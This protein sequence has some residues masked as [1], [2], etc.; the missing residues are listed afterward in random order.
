MIMAYRIYDNNSVSNAEKHYDSVANSAPV[1][2]DSAATTRQDN[3]LI[4]MPNR[5]KTVL[6]TAITVA[7]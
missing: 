4:N 1:Y 5:I 7:I 6:T 2:S 3:R